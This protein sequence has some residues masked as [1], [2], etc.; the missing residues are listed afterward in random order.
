MKEERKYEFPRFQIEILEI[1]E[2][3]SKDWKNNKDLSI[4]KDRESTGQNTR[5]QISRKF[6]NRKRVSSG[7]FILLIH[8]EKHINNS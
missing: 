5:Y 4:P 1:S 2:I 7:N 6:Y 3:K 8:H